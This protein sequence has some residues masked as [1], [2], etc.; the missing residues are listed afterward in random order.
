MLRTVEKVRTYAHT[1]PDVTELE[2]RNRE[3]AREIA[4]EGIVLLTNDGALPLA[5]GSK[6]ALLGVGAVRTTKG[7]S[8][9]GEVNE[10]YSVSIYEGMKEAGF[11]L[12][13]ER[14]LQHYAEKARQ[15]RAAYVAGK[16]KQAGFLSM[17][18]INMA[19]IKQGYDEAPFGPV[20]AYELQ[21]A[22][23]CVYVITRLSGEG[24][25]RSLEAGDYYLTDEEIA[26]LHTAAAYYE[27]MILVINT[28][29]PVDL[30]KV[31]DIPFSAILN[32]GML[33]EEGG[34]AFAD[35]IS[36][37]VSPS[38]HLTSTWPVRYEDIPFGESYSDLDG[39]P[40]TG[41]Y[42]EDIFVGYRYY[43]RFGVTPRFIF[44]QGLSYTAFD[45][46]AAVSAEESLQISLHVR[47]VGSHTGKCVPQIYLSS[48]E[49]KLCQ[50]ERVLIG[51]A[52]TKELAPGEGQELTVSVPYHYMASF[53]ETRGAE[54]MEK[55][56]Y[57]VSLG[58]NSRDT[59]AIAAFDLEE[60]VVLTGRDRICPEK[61]PVQKLRPEQKKPMPEV[62]EELMITVD[63]KNIR[64]EE[65]RQKHH[66]MDDFQEQ[67]ERLVNSLSDKELSQLLTGEGVL[68]IVI[69]QKH[70]TVVPGATGNSTTKLEKKGIR[71]IAFCDGPAGLRFARTS[72]VKPGRNRIHYVEVSQDMMN[73]MPSAIRS[74]G[75]AKLSDGE[76]LYLY[77]T[78]FPTGTALAQTWNEEL[79]KKMGAAVGDEME[80]YGATVWLAPGMN[81]HRNPLCGRNYE[82]YSEDPLLAGKIGAGI[83]RGVQT[84]PACVA[85]IKHFFCNN[86]ENKRQ[87]TSANAGER[88]LREIYLR[89]FGIVIKEAGGRAL[90]SSYNMINGIWAGVCKDSLSTVLRDEWGFEGIVV[91]DWDSSHKGL[92]AE[93]SIDAGIT[94]LM[95]GN[96][97]QRKAIV[98]ALKNGSL[99]R[100]VARARAVKNVQLILLHQSL[101]E[102]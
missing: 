101:E 32:I 82:Y 76:P 27:K 84:H 54:V 62:S 28:G 22:D 8:G 11:E 31:D 53:D 55:G 48:P 15:D 78:A 93:K 79:A 43:E 25:D 44:G 50:P 33:G 90:M 9:S 70:S 74:L 24:T 100:E 92:E 51:F 57:M 56:R 35:V 34:N 64:A 13:N 45:M 4:R 17:E 59:C 1:T 96:G 94:M 26:N 60:T 98:K 85:T 10:R 52:K 12:V 47:N 83:I 80:E 21:P 75:N 42:R 18:A 71:S 38:G 14:R 3:I 23:A 36:G 49:D 69:P 88:A 72:I 73:F 87:W 39:H 65:I 19:N 30:T 58:E 68:D 5:R 37:K 41:D 46:R 66:P 77:A 2:L 81:I 20:E 97:G 63:P 6:I 86:Q 29:G 67:A 7:G 16:R 95:G 61:T 89:S 91:T 99:S 40:E 102:A